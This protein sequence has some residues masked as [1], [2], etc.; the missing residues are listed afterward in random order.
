MTD[1]DTSVQVKLDALEQKNANL[2][3]ALLSARSQLSELHSKLDKISAPPAQIATFVF[4]DE[5][6]NE[7]EVLL[8]SRQMRIAAAPDFDF[9]GASPGQLIRVNEESIAVEPMGFPSDGTVASVVEGVGTD[10]VLVGMEGGIERVL[11]LSGPLLH[12]NV[13]PGD[14]VL[15]DLHSGYVYERIVRSFVEQLLTPEIPDVSYED[16]GGLDSQIEQVR[17]A[18]ELPFKHPELYRAYGLRP[19]R[20]ILLYGPPG[21]GKTLIAKAVATSLSVPDVDRKAYFISIK[22]PELL[23]KYVGETERHIR[24]IFA[25]AK[26]LA[27]SDVPVVVFFDEMEALFRT[28]GSGISS[29]V[30]TMIV[31]QLLAE[32]DGLESMENVVVIGASNRADMIDPA[33]LRP[34]RL[35]VRVR[36]DRPTREQARDIFAKHLDR[37][38][39]IKSEQ[40]KSA[41]SHEA[42]IEQMIEAALDMLYSRDDAA[43]LFD[44]NLVDGS[45]H[46]VYIS[47]LVSGA[48]IA[49][50][51]ERAKKMAIKATL[52]GAPGGLSTHDILEGVAQESRES[53]ELAATTSPDEWART[54]GMRGIEVVSVIPLHAASNSI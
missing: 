30:E 46:R 44:V 34:G 47:D 21:C 6:K 37:E 19:P 28:R 3:R 31:P 10:R 17:D 29:D 15:A 24:A 9:E 32:M 1:T 7:V 22:G 51:V 54:V 8:G 16:I 53:A 11:K 20:G 42:A 2:T 25:R 40:M 45:K 39:P 52:E 18:V 48:M 27:A 36:I 41:G 13:K 38:L 14:T 5:R 4:A 49:G 50:T 26:S 33:V 35:D 12:G 23:N 43:A